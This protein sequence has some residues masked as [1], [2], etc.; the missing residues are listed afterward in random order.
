MTELADKLQLKAGQG[1]RVLDAPADVALGHG[2]ADAG[3]PVG[4]LVFVRFAAEV[5]GVAAQM[6]VAAA[7]ADQLAW[8]AYPEAGQLG[9]DLNRDRLAAALAAHGIRP[10]RQISLDDTWSA[11]R[12]RAARAEEE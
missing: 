4:A 10:V 12:F 1:L 5:S 6:A 8:V 11:L 7:K 9:T 3:D 2:V